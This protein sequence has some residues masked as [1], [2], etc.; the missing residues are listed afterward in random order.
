MAQTDRFRLPLLAAGQAQKE[1]TH[2]EALSLIDLA[3]GRTVESVALASPP[4]SPEPGQCWIVASGGEG[5]W[6]G[7]DHAIAGWTASGWRLLDPFEGLICWVSDIQ[8]CVR[9]DGFSWIA[10][11]ARLDGFY[12]GEQRVVGTRQPAI[13]NPGG[14]ATA[15]PEARAAIN[16]MLDALRAHGLIGS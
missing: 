9:F 16:A 1:L 11:G 8:H 14:G 6:V 2:N 4:T 13:A 12:V 7:R 15:D 3:M 10:Q 5:A